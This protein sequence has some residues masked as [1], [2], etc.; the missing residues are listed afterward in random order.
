M[1][2]K[3]T[4]GST[5]Y[6]KHPAT[7]KVR[8]RIAAMAP[9]KREA[10]L[11]KSHEYQAIRACCLRESQ[12]PSYL[13]ASIAQRRTM[14]VANARTLLEKRRD[15]GKIDG[16]VN[17]NDIV[18]RHLQKEARE[19]TRASVGV[20]VP[21]SGQ[22]LAMEKRETVPLFVTPATPAAEDGFMKFDE[23]EGEGD[24][25]LSAVAVAYPDYAVVRDIVDALRREVACLKDEVGALR[26][27]VNILRQGDPIEDD[28]L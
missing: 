19:R 12:R 23:E 9:A 5:H 17:L 6:S 13:N 18:T 14:L 10:F 4:R 1:P 24:P 11:A 26:G 28:F 2:D 27:E 21:P 20:S 3:R 25:E 15:A 16:K 22:G 8:A 7:R